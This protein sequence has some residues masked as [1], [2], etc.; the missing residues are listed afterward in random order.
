[1]IRLG[2]ESRAQVVW[3]LMKF[4]K[5]VGHR[6]GDGAGPWWWPEYGYS[7]VGGVIVV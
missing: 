7:E 2:R 5:S 3:A 4:M 1:M 6:P